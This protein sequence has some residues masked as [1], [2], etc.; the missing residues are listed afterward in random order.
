MP[1]HYYS[2]SHYH[3]KPTN[4]K[5]TAGSA[6]AAPQSSQPSNSRKWVRPLH[7]TTAPAPNA[8]PDA[9][10]QSKPERRPLLKGPTDKFGSKS[11]RRD[12]SQQHSSNP[13]SRTDVSHNATQKRSW[14]RT[15]EVQAKTKELERSSFDSRS[16]HSQKV[17]SS[18]EKLPKESDTQGGQRHDFGASAGDSQTLDVGEESKVN[19][20]VKGHDGETKKEESTEDTKKYQWKRIGTNKLVQPHAKEKVNGLRKDSPIDQPETDIQDSSE[21][22]K[23]IPLHE[24]KDFKRLGRNK[25]VLQSK[26]PP[27]RISTGT[28]PKRKI[29]NNK[30][31]R[32][33]KRIRI[34]AAKSDDSG[35]ESSSDEGKEKPK[36]ASV[37]TTFAYCQPTDMKAK[38]RGRRPASHSLVRVPTNDKTRVCP[39]FAR[40]MTCT[41]EACLLRHDVP[42][43]AT[44]PTC[45]HFLQNGM[46]LKDKCP[47]RHVKGSEEP[48]PQWSKTGYCTVENCPLAH[49]QHKNKT[50]T[51]KSM[52]S[53]QP[54]E[55]KEDE[56]LLVFYDD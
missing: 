20:D 11:W 23:R 30:T 14:K 32:N 43:E 56:K 31:P 40:G 8:V 51:N 2:S 48:C 44:Q 3:R 6:A 38:R 55:P 45:H 47:F 41:K 33:A 34:T 9:M 18:R 5:W 50:L 28:K 37:L 27:E 46:C 21:N 10:I 29:D 36:D 4:K 22:T 13:A 54:E 49:I 52:K 12:A 42:A 26:D 15:E 19:N 35:E 7:A 1:N 16:N 17:D 24:Q 25:L 53:K 39:W